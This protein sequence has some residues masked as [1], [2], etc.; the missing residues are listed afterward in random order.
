MDQNQ[1]RPQNYLVLAILST[2]FCCMPA[3]VVSIIYAAKVNGLYAEGRYNEAIAASKNAKTWGIV[4]LV[5][6][7]LLWIILIAIYGF[8]IFAIL[9]GSGE[10]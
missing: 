1:P 4:S 7:I 3:G 5:S 10:F 9:A 6:A 2:I 8:A